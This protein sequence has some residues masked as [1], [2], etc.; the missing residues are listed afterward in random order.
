MK[1]GGESIQLCVVSLNEPQQSLQPHWRRFLFHSSLS[2]ISQSPCA[3]RAR[4][5]Y[6]IAR[7]AEW[8]P[9][10]IMT[11]SMCFVW[12]IVGHNYC[13]AFN[14]MHKCLLSWTIYSLTRRFKE[15]GSHWR[16][17]TEKFIASS[18]PSLLQ[19]FSMLSN[20]CCLESVLN[21]EWSV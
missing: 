9:S 7:R 19:V 18:S 10:L 16:P 13:D 12:V 11:S 1:T 2:A 17:A 6:R 20:L 21:S 4:T 14:S 5:L 3:Y 8:L 15:G